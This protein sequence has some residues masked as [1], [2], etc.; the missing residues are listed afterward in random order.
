MRGHLDASQLEFSIK[1]EVEASGQEEKDVVENG[2]ESDNNI[3]EKVHAEVTDE[4]TTEKNLN[5]SQVEKSGA[6]LHD[7]L[8]EK[9][10][11]CKRNKQKNVK[12]KERLLRFK[13]K[14][15]DWWS[16]AQ[17]GLS[18]GFYLQQPILCSSPQTFFGLS[19][20]VCL[21]LQ[22]SPVNLFCSSCLMFGRVFTLSQ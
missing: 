3:K 16:N 18:F 6:N 17:Q 20:P 1:A 14:L 22:P 4:V 2:L 10:K 7:Y 9:R 13:Q 15:V 12:K 19:P 11:D 8:K 5:L 21:H